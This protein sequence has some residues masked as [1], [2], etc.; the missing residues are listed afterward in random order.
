MSV[1]RTFMGR[2]FLP[3]APSAELH[4]NI[5]W[6]TVNKTLSRKMVV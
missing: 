3:P 6:N 5:G 1:D 2:V 4:V